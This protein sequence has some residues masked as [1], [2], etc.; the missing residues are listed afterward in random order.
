[1]KSANKNAAG[2]ALLSGDCQAQSATQAVWRFLNNPNVSLVD[3]IAP[4]RKVGQKA[5]RESESQYVLLAHDWCKIDY[6][7]HSSKRD[8]R[9]ITHEHDVG[10]E[11]STSL[12]IDAATGGAIAPMQMHLKTSSKVHSTAV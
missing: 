12:L 2:P 5:A 8:L 6:K 7:S 3:L 11:M 9:Q 10:Y 1:M 4:L